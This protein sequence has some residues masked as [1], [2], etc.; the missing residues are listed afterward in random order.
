MTTA[1]VL[2]L[3]VAICAA[4]TDWVAVGTGRRGLEFVA[5]PAVMVA[6]V[7]LAVALVPGSSASDAARPWFVA[8]LLLSL[9]G[10]VLLM[11]PRERFV[12]G[13]IA[14]LLAHLAYIV[15]L[16]VIAL[17]S[18]VVPVGVVIGLVVV[19]SIVLFVGL[20]VVRA[21][22][23]GRPRLVVPVVAYLAVISS[24]VVVACATGRPVAIAGALLFYASDA[25]LAW[26]RFVTPKRWGRVATHVTYHA[27]QALLVLSLL[28]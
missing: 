14:F 24:M 26:D 13:L 2:C 9:A 5:K 20:P 19:G 21:V 1:A 22:R 11:L 16:G 12:G 27:G 8:A 10:D 17:V 7:G 15:G 4:I 6:L 18:G 28:G 25:I 3:L 23:L